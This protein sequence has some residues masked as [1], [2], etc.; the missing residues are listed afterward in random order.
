MCLVFS[1]L[2]R[3]RKNKQDLEQKTPCDFWE[4]KWKIIPLESPQGNQ[5]IL[6]ISSAGP[7]F[8]NHQPLEGETNLTSTDKWVFR[9]HFGYRLV[10]EKSNNNQITLYDEIDNKIY[11]AEK[12]LKK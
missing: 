2:L 8:L 6:T 11:H 5:M 3:K 7:I 4:G 1:W 12:V 9:D 10:L